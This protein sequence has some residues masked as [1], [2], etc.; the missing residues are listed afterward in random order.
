MSHRSGNGNGAWWYPAVDTNRRP[1][2]FVVAAAAAAV[3][4]VVVHRQ[5]HPRQQSVSGREICHT[6]DVLRKGILNEPGRSIGLEE[7][8]AG[9]HTRVAA[10]QGKFFKERNVVTSAAACGG[11]LIQKI[12]FV[13]WF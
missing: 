8:L 11:G 6:V 1:L 2:W 7:F 4:V 12:P 9:H 10:G 13:P 5:E 3:V